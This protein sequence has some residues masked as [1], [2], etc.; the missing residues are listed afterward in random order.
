MSA[1]RSRTTWA[2]L[3][4]VAGVVLIGSMFLEWYT[5]DLPERIRDPEADLPTFTGFEGLKRADV[6]LVAAA[7]LGVIIA[8][9]VFAGI[10][11]NSPAPGVAL[12]LVSLFALAVVLYRGVISPPGLVL[13]GVGLEMQVSFGW[14]VSLVAAVVMVVGGLLTYLGGPHLEFEGGEAGSSPQEQSTDGGRGP[15]S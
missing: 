3:A 8:G 6:A 5:L 12:V 13:F 15:L 4:A 2:L 1:G 7:G 11:A 9:L 10:L 14:F